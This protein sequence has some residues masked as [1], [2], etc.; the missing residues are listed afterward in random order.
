MSTR[1]RRSFLT[2]AAILAVISPQIAGSQEYEVTDL[3][4][5]GISNQPWS[6]NA[7]GQVAGWSR[8]PDG[9]D[10]GFFFD[11]STIGYIGTPGPTTRSDLLGINDLGEAVGKSG[12]VHENGEALLRRANGSVRRLGTLGGSRSAALSINDV[13]QIVG[14]SKLAGDAESRPFIWEDGV[15]TP[16][17]LLG[18]GQGEATWIN[19]RGQIVGSSTTDT[20]GLTQFAVIWEEGMVTRLPPMYPGRPDLNNIAHYIHDNGDIAGS[21]RIPETPPDFTTRGAIWR[22]GQVHLQLGTLADGTPIEPEATSWASG[23]N[24]SGVVVGMSINAQRELVPFVYR[25]DEMVQLDDLMPDPWVATFVGAGAI[26]DAGQIA[27]SALG[28][29]GITHALLLTP[30]SSTAVGGPDGSGHDGGPYL[31][32]QGNRITFRIPHRGPVTVSVFDVTGRLTATLVDE[33]RPAGDHDVVWN[34]QTRGGHAVSSGVY[35]VRMS[36]PGF[37]ASSR[38][39]LV[40]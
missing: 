21:I 4:A 31:A 14:W 12:T 13:S 5:L 3:G 7:L 38:L 22:D 30:T 20:N 33:V 24:A 9:H 32:A 10:E 39:L 25:N 40:R 1:L 8:F 36:L 2:T 34:G 37:V 23:I 19:N 28:V 16:L 26:N 6:V 35:F 29:D 11:G 18:G 15:M 27:V 17:P